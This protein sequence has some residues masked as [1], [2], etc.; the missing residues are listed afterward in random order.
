MNFTVAIVGRPNVGKSTLFNRLVGKRLALVDDT[1]GLTRDRREGDA[2]LGDLRFMAIDTA[3]LEEAPAKALEARMRAQTE[4]AVAEADVILFVIDARV[5]ITPLDD[6]FTDWL[7]GKG[8]PVIALANKCEGTVSPP[9]LLEAYNLGLG[10]PVAVSAEHGQG[11]DALYEALAPHAADKQEETHDETEDDAPDVAEDGSP[12]RPLK[13]AIVGRPNVGK[14]TLV[15]RLLGEDRV[16]TDPEAGITRDAVH[17]PWTYKGRPISLV[18][19]AGLRRKARVT[20]RLEA[21]SGGDAVRTLRFAEVVVLVLDAEAPLEKQDL[22]IAR[23]TLEEGRAL[24]LAVNKWDLVKDRKTAEK[25]VSD[26]LRTSLPQARGIPVVSFS[27]LTG[28]GVERLMPTVLRVHETWNRRIPTGRLNRWLEGVCENH[29][30]PLA[31]GRRIRLRYI[32]QA[33]ARPPTFIIFASRPDGLPESYSRYLI[34]SLRDT[35]G[36]PGIPLR[37]HLRKGKNPYDSEK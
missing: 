36:L 6:H 3:G 23:T 20:D 8:K 34:N 37:I 26:R 5:G 18:D 12:D 13:M 35:F 30:P 21:L 9:G 33:K 29:P 27:A 16:L 10:D 28:R 14:S 24:I 1:P 7:R 25:R 22:T 2:R 11:M 17:I 31:A 4:H 19:T 32:T 15:N